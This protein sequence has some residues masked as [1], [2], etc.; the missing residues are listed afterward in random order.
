MSQ[1]S[2]ANSRVHAYM[3]G[4]VST[5]LE[6]SRI[7]LYLLWSVASWPVDVKAGLDRLPP[8]ACVLT[9][10]DRTYTKRWICMVVNVGLQYLR[11]L[12]A[13]VGPL[14]ISWQSRTK[15]LWSVSLIRT[16]KQHRDLERYLGHI[17]SD[18]MELL[19][20]RLQESSTRDS[21]TT[22]LTDDRLDFVNEFYKQAV[23]I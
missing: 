3:G 5:S 10:S 19:G 16:P 1:L 9:C 13:L 11:A 18:D 8:C 12:Q 2:T 4:R 15:F 14:I 21:G 17:R 22:D 7:V 20:I 23:D 6:F